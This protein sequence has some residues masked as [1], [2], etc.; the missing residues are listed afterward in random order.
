MAAVLLQTSS[1]ERSLGSGTTQTFTF[2]SPVPAGSA[3]I[4]PFVNFP[5]GAVTGVTDNQGN[6]YSLAQSVTVTE[7]RTD[8]WYKLN[9]SSDN[10][11]PLVLTATFSAGGNYNTGAAT[12]WS[13]LSA[14]DKVAN[15]ANSG[16]VTAPSANTTLDSIAIVSV[17]INGGHDNGALG[18]PAGWNTIWRENN[19]NS[20][21][22]GQ[23]GW[24]L[25]P[26]NEVATVTSSNSVSNFLNNVLATFTVTP[27]A[28]GI[29][30]NL[31]STSSLNATLSTSIRVGSSLSSA[32]SLNS[33][34]SSGIRLNSSISSLA[35]LSPSL[36]NSIRLGSNP[37]VS[38]QVTA[39]LTTGIRASTQLSSSSSASAALSTSIRLNQNYNGV[40]SFG[41][42][43]ST[44]IN[45]SSAFG[46]TVSLTPT[47][48]SL[49]T[50]SASLIGS[51][52]LSPPL[53]TQ[54][55]A[56][57]QIQS[58]SVISGTL[59]NAAQTSFSCSFVVSQTLTSSLQT[60]VRF[61]TS[62]MG[63]SIATADLSTSV[64]LGS[65]IVSSVSSSFS[66]STGIL[67]GSTISSLTEFSSG[68]ST[69][70]SL[71]SNLN[72]ESSLVVKLPEYFYSL[73]SVASS[74]SG[75]LGNIST[76][77][78]GIKLHVRP[79]VTRVVVLNENSIVSVAPDYRVIYV[80][81]EE[82]YVN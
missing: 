43:I 23:A 34:L 29:G 9:I 11:T 10:T 42:G 15:S 68:L 57:T 73:F 77:T 20:Y 12:A 78:K 26:A 69:G 82:E 24:K 22:G 71:A 52:T 3:V 46:S 33:S 63:S 25:I 16:T 58:N 45:L 27:P 55:T 40:S 60:G 44:G 76:A 19:S 75:T 72:S 30:S 47:L 61:S 17:V 53:Q 1:V 70:I 7:N 49:S 14:L 2:A 74:F 41:A 80:S 37:S 50:F 4:I 39:N 59:S 48:G 81:R 65:S 6:T 51:S 5:G 54:I 35:A 28:A 18:F 21:E 56:S 66:L 67:F 13:G 36:T 32:S 64:Q 8:I 38:S 79:D 31:V 62:L